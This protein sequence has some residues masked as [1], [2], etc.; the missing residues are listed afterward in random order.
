M[1]HYQ[2]KQNH[3]YFQITSEHLKMRK[4]ISRKCETE[5]KMEFG[6]INQ[7]NPNGLQLEKTATQISSF[8]GIIV[9]VMKRRGKTQMAAHSN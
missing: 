5:Q 1:S 3:A 9:Y 4:N 2:A 8:N 7:I 6:H